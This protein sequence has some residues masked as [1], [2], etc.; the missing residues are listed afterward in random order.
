MKAI[1]VIPAY[2]EAERIGRII[3]DVKKQV[4]KVIVVDDGSRDATA[5]NAQQKGAM[6]VSHA[7]NLG[8]GAAL[9][10]GCDVALKLKADAIIVM[11]ADGQHKASDIP[12]F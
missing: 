3:P 10:T 1:A 4:D 8:K 12:L 2:N 5:R 7:V 6:V 9:K 11:D